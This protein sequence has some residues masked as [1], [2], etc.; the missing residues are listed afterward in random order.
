MHASL[1]KDHT[2]FSLHN[3]RVKVLKRT[4]ISFRMKNGMNSFSNELYVKKN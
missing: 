1:A 4:R 2:I 3:I